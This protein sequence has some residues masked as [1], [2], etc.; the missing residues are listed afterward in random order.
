M[1][2]HCRQLLVVSLF[3]TIFLSLTGCSWF[4]KNNTANQNTK[5]VKTEEPKVNQDVKKTEQ[6]RKEKE[7]SNGQVYIEKDVVMATMLIKDDVSEAD[8]K[9][10]AE[11]YA[12]QLKEEHKDMKVNVQAVQK[13]KNIANITIEK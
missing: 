2:K 3:I 10:L 12:K 5:S 13:G 7:I 9:A 8:A 6:L 1:K 4:S 11:K